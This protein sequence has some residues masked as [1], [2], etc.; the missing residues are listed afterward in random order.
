[1]IL[2]IILNNFMHTTELHS[3][4]FSTCDVRSALNIRSDFPIIWGFRFMGG[5]AQH[6][7][8]AEK[9]NE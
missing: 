3:G 6:T 4:E 9:Q 8:I 5:T 7:L 2:T 1:M